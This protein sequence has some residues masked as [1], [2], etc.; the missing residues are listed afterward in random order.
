MQLIEVTDRKSEKMFLDTAR[1]IYRNDDTWV[2]PLDDHIRAVFDPGK[3]PYYKHGT[4][5]RWVL[6][7]GDNSLI[8]RIAAFIDFNLANT[9]DQP[10]GGIGF[11]ECIDDDQAAEM[12]FNTAREWLRAEGMEAMDGPQNFGETDKYWGLLV[13]GFTHPS[14][15]IAYNP[16]YYQGLFERYGF[17]TYYKMEG[18]HYDLTKPLDARFRKIAE[19]VAAKPGYEFRHFTWK[20]QDKY[21]ADFAEVF[22]EAWASFKA[23]F[24]PL[25]P[26]Y[27]KGVLKKAK[28]ILDEEFIWLAYFEGKPIAIYLMF[29]DLNQ[30]LKHLN[31]KLDLWSMIRFIWLKKR[32]TMTRARGMLMGVIPRYQ[33]LG[34]ESAFILKL[35]EAIK[36]KPHYKEV[37]FSWVGDFNPKMRKIFVSVGSVSVKHY[38]TYRYLFDRTKEFKRYPIPDIK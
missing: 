12:L 11:F 30:I 1:V 35:R 14:F 8:G 6:T 7:G 3:N 20:E 18:F 38:I 22:N 33:G 17:Q 24:E 37:E 2:C 10:T 25:E 28:V 36:H 29:P 9:Y 19:W 34:I 21:V 15:E 32:K 4:A 5:I 23:N 16:P 27:I 26:D 31:G 13:D